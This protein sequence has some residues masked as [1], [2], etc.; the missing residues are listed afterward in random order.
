MLKG[1]THMKTLTTYTTTAYRERFAMSAEDVMTRHPLS[2]NE[3]ATLREAAA[4]LT[5]KGISAAPVINDAGRPVGVLSLADIVRSACVDESSAAGPGTPVREVMTP[6]VFFVRPETR[7][8]SVIDDLLTCA[9][10]R[11]FVVH[12]HEVLIGV[13]STLDLL[14]FLHVESTAQSSST[15][16]R[17]KRRRTPARDVK[18][19]QHVFETSGSGSDI[20]MADAAS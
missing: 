17:T 1:V 12:E 19:H 7:V 9:V 10:H 2:I 16:P 8:G 5:E 4:F 11:L 15:P 14:R 13:I 6:V 3:S 18:S 20:V